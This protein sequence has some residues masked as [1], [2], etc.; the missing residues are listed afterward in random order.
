MF[1]IS[2]WEILL[3]LIIALIVIGPKR[4]PEVAK[5]TGKWLRWFRNQITGIRS[6]IERELD[7]QEYK[8]GASETKKNGDNNGT[9]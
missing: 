4:L 8:K 1:S 5:T 3:I 9:D 6:D 2:F 7:A